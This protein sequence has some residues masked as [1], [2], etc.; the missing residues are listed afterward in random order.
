MNSIVSNSPLS[1]WLWQGDHSDHKDE[2]SQLGVRRVDDPK[3]PR[4]HRD[5]RSSAEMRKLMNRKIALQNGA[6]ALCKG[7]SQTTMM[8]FPTTSIH[9]AWEELGGT[10]IPT[11]SKRCIG[12]ATVEPNLTHHRCI[13][14]G[15]PKK[16][17]AN[18][19]KRRHF[20]SSHKRVNIESSEQKLTCQHPTSM[21]LT[22]KSM[23]NKQ[24]TDRR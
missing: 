11:T 8:S 23:C 2:Q 6:C 5:I 10:T 14:P 17:E 13:N 9:E 7:S 22:A 3:H 21:A 1:G 4:G 18:I 16:P 24:R 20:L 19:A 15:R 12:G